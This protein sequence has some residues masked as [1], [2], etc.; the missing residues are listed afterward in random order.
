MPQS[1]YSQD[2]RAAL[3]AVI[4]GAKIEESDLQRTH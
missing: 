1:Q 2:E 3:T 4:I